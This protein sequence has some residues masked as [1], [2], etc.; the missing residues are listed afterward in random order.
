MARTVEVRKRIERILDET[1][2][3]PR[4]LTRGRWAALLACSLPLLYAASVAKLAPAQAIPATPRAGYAQPAPAPAPMVIAQVRPAPPAPLPMPTGPAQS[5]EDGRL[6]VLYFDLQAIPA[7]DQIRVRDYAQR[8]LDS[9]TRA[10][11]RVAI[12]TNS[13]ELKVVQDFTGDHDLLSQSIRS[14]TGSSDISDSSRQLAVLE[15]AVRM[16]A[17][18]PGKKALIYFSSGSQR[19][20]SAE[21]ALYATLRAAGQANVAFYPV[22]VRDLAGGAVFQSVVTASAQP[23]YPHIAPID[24]A[25]IQRVDPVYPTQ[26][27]A[28]GVEGDVQF[29]IIVGTD[30]RVRNAQLIGGN[31][32]LEA[33]AREAVNQY[34]YSP[35][36][37]ANGEGAELDTTVT[38]PF[39]LNGA[40]PV[41]SAA[42]EEMRVLT[43]NYHAEYGGANS[44]GPIG[45]H[46]PQLRYKVEP[47]YPFALRAQNV[48]GTVTLAVTI[49]VGGVPRDIHVTQSADPGLDAQAIAAAGRWQFTPARKDGQPVEA[50]A[51]LQFTFRLQ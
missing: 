40:P 38:V 30:G 32:L 25:P 8:F 18:L 37:M 29:R 33:A 43:R 35:F 9:Q 39:R 44:A 19:D 21:A 20:I 23:P 12:M 16:L 48:Q 46:P 24:T 26:A 51:I 10:A 42:V 5:Q 14:L 15:A 1:R 2:Q 22:D 45:D 34:L 47:E 49:D 31:P 28:A 4:G 6:V 13:G 3:I 41:Q 27:I 11:D 17:P 36:K 50:P 7:D